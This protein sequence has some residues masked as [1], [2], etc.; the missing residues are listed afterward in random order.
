ATQA[1]LVSEQAEKAIHYNILKREVDTNRQ[2]Y[3]SMLHKVKEYSIASAM[4]AS[5]IRVVDPARAPLLPYKPD[6]FQYV[7]T[8]LL[9]GLVLGVGIVVLRERADR[10]I[11]TQGDAPFYLK[12]PELGVIPAARN[13]PGMRTALS[14][15]RRWRMLPA[16]SG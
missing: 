6:L 16:N 1:R 4:H 10:S 11:Q 13:D 3:D 9:A 8:G 12:L 7:Q 2:L 15:L 5:N 14:G